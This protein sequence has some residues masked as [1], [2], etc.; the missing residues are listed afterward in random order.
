MDS[1]RDAGACKGRAQAADV[2][3]DALRVV[4][5]ERRAVLAR[6]ALRIVTRKQEALIADLESGA[7]PPGSHRS[8]L[9]QAIAMSGRSPRRITDVRARA[10]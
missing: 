1:V 4:Y 10:P 2:R 3:R 8:S 7:G 6:D 9:T 5:V